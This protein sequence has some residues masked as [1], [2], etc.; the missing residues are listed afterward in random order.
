MEVPL[1]VVQHIPDGGIILLRYDNIKTCFQI[2][3][4][5]RVFKSQNTVE[6]TYFQ[7]WSCLNYGH[8]NLEI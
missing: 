2:S 7:E 5:K 1:Y 6:K 4:S 3:K 8:W